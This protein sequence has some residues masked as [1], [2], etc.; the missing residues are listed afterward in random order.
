MKT[1]S[2]PRY[3]Q[4]LFDLAQDK[5]ALKE[6]YEDLK[7]LLAAVK[8]SP[9]LAG[10]LKNPIIPENKQQQIIEEAFK[11]KMNPLTYAFLNFLI[12]RRRLSQFPAIA[13]GFENFY[14]QKTG[15]MNVKIASVCPLKPEQVQQISSKL[16]AYFKKDIQPFFQIDSQLLGGFKI[17]VGDLIYDFTIKHQLEVFELSVMKR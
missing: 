3:A 15:I 2:A 4:A 16:K 11:T 13:E 8:A 5:G 7:S 14:L 12:K 6:V 1:K 9:E 10:F 17:A